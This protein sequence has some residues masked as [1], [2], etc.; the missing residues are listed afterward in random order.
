MTPQELATYVRFKTRTNAVTFSDAQILALLKLRKDEI[1]RR[2]LDADEDIF[3]DP[4]FANL[5]LGQREYSLP[6]DTL[7]RIKR[8]EAKFDGT[9]WIPL[10]EIDINDLKY[11]TNED[12]ILSHFSNEAGNA[13]YDISRKSL[14]L[15]CGE[16]VAVV[17]G[18]KLWCNTYPAE[19][20]DLSSILEMN[21][22]PTSL[23]HGIP[24]EVHELLARGIIIDYKESREKPI[25]LTEKELKYDVDLERAIQTLRHGNLDRDVIA[26]LPPASDR[27][28]NGQDY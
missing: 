24:R 22:A 5:G 7:S 13:K 26:E 15:Y 23:T 20:T 4:E 1:A 14:W 3:V 11:T 27:G 18:L 9:A 21:I 25:P 8:V 12:D 28:N 19:I 10:S 6:H 2:I 16:I 17:K